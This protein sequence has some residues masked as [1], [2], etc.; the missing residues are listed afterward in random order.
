MNIHEFCFQYKS[1]NTYSK[2]KKE[3]PARTININK[4]KDLVKKPKLLENFLFFL[5]K[6]LKII[7]KSA[8]NMEK[9]TKTER[10]GAPWGPRGPPSLFWLVFPC[11]F[12]DFL[13]IFK[14][15][16]KK[17]KKFSSSFGFFI[18]SFGFFMFMVLAGR[19]T[20]KRSFNLFVDLARTVCPRPLGK[21]GTSATQWEFEYFPN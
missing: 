8:K 19:S 5:P 12:I 15:F 6:T 16:G 4:P 21:I 20:L 1:R 10:V 13:M 18:K 7:R 3:R 9:P 11:F 2:H 17:T 14:V